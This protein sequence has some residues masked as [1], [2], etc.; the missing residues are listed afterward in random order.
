MPTESENRTK[1]SLSSP[2]DPC[3]PCITQFWCSYSFPWPSDP[4]LHPNK[5][6]W[7]R[8]I[9]H[10][11]WSLLHSKAT[12]QRWIE[13]TRHDALGPR[14][15]CPS[16]TSWNTCFP[17]PI[18]PSIT[19]VLLVPHKIRRKNVQVRGQ[20]CE[21]PQ[22]TGFFFVEHAY[23][24]TYAARRL[25]HGVRRQEKK[26]VQDEM[27]YRWCVQHGENSEDGGRPTSEVPS[28][29]AGNVRTSTS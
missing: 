15:R 2:N 20:K 14:K 5:W 23:V 1:R 16:R 26:G 18:T 4:P 13:D 22:Y 19:N 6:R 25:L 24:R 21:W 9:Q 29:P 3:D 12:P 8:G 10:S 7:R 28:M 11:C 27:N 17:A